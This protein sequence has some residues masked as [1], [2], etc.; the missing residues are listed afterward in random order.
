MRQP[1]LTCLCA[2]LV[3]GQTPPAD[4]ALSPWGPSSRFPQ[5]YL[6]SVN[7][8]LQ[9]EHAYR[10]ADYQRSSTLLQAFWQSHPPGTEPW[11]TEIE[12]SY[13]IGRTT[14]ANFGAPVAY[15]ALRMLTDCVEWRLRQQP[16]VKPQSVQLTVVL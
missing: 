9:A 15:Y 1:A 4:A 5:L 6:D 2:A 16:K 13:E 12:R 10:E 8:F 3:L 7:T 14:G 11:A